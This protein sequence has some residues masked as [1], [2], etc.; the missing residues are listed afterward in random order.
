MNGITPSLIDVRYDANDALVGQLMAWSS[1]LP[2]FLMVAFA[3][4]L[5]VRR[6]LQF[7]AFLAGI[8]A[9]EL[10]SVLLK[11]LIREPRPD[12]SYMTGYGMPSSHAQFMCFAAVFALMH[13]WSRLAFHNPLLVRVSLSSLILS[14]TLLVCFSRWYMG[15]HSSKQIAVGAFLGIFLGVGYYR[16]VQSIFV[17]FVFPVLE[18]SGIGRFF[19]LRDSSGIPNI[20]S[21][22]HDSFLKSK[23]K[24]EK[25][26]KRS[27]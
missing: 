18:N 13:L 5:S 12:G 20:L 25:K 16:V 26:M 4:V 7:V 3:G 9:S 2:I 27:D 15:V 22:E 8:L 14:S 17:P 6:E 10:L 19:Y 23:S 24:I 21:Y 11:R 1:M